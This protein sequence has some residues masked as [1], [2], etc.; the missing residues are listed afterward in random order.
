MAIAMQPQKCLAAN[1]IRP[2]NSLSSL[3]RRL[4][5]CRLQRRPSQLCLLMHRCASCVCTTLALNCII[6]K[7][8]WSMCSTTVL[9]EARHEMWMRCR[10]SDALQKFKLLAQQVSCGLHMMHVLYVQKFSC[11][12]DDQTGS[13]LSGQN[14]VARSAHGHQT[15]C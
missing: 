6:R 11:V 1:H 14:A 2:N 7:Q 4:Q 10:P 3:S 15:D 5:M 9:S 12:Q 13:A 8:R